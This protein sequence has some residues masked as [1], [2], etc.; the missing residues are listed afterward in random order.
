LLLRPVVWL[1]YSAKRRF[2]FRRAQRHVHLRA[3]GAV[4]AGVPVPVGN[5]DKTLAFLFRSS[6]T[7]GW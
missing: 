7:Q 2:T 4:D 6:Y 3:A 5:G 1:L